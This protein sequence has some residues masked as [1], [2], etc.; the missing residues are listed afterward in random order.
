VPTDAGIEEFTERFK[1]YGFH[2]ESIRVLVLAQL[3]KSI[4]GFQEW[5]KH[6][7]A[8]LLAVLLRVLL[9]WLTCPI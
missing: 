2:R 8:P 9:L 7:F 6:I 1:Q 5:K 3:V 4:K